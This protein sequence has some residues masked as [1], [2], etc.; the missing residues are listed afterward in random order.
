MHKFILLFRSGC[1]SNIKLATVI[2]A[3]FLHL[4]NEFLMAIKQRL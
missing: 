4:I 3:P 1:K 2:I